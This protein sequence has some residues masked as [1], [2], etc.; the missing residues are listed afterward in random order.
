M[1][2]E[3]AKPVGLS[4]N[5]DRMSGRDRHPT[6]LGV[7]GQIEQP[8]ISAIVPVFREE[9]SI[10]LFLSRVEPILEAIGS[11][12]I[13]FCYD[14]SPD[15]TKEVILEEIL[16]NPRIRLLSF[17]RRFGQPA[18]VMAGLHHCIGKSCVVLDV[19][20][21]DPPELITELYHKLGEGYD[22]VLA[23]RRKRNESEPL[24][25][26][27]MSFVGYRV[28]NALSDV[29]IPKDT[30]EFR[31]MNR[32]VIDEL[33]RL[34]EGH[35]FLRG[36]VAFVGFNQTF[37]EFDRQERVAGDSNYPRYFGSI[38]IGLNG[39]IGFSTALLT[40]TLFAG[41]AIAAAAL[42]IGAY[43]VVRKL[44][45]GE[46]YPLGFPTITLLVALLGGVQL[47]AIGILGEYVGRVYDEVKNRPIYIVDRF[48]NPPTAQADQASTSESS[49]R[50]GRPESRQ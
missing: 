18:A 27:L 20:L 46:D 11:Y 12:E 39:L 14:P 34:K 37:V 26:R 2:T 8:E 10:R 50:P 47:V 40:G 16:R 17:S 9:K 21:Q 3:P 6:A 24:I 49:V 13:L 23:K 43:V 45:F 44:G 38:R 19:D 22:V 4:A 15:R 33:C 1:V 42:L 28:I 41:I 29:E 32:R 30:G 7:A 25:R 31:I 5:V 48:F 36:L 35:G